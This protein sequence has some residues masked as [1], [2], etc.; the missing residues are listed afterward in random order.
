MKEELINLKSEYEQTNETNDKVVQHLTEKEQKRD[1][2]YKNDIAAK[3]E[4]ISKFETELAQLKAKLEELQKVQ[5]NEKEEVETLISEK[6][7][8]KQV[9][10]AGE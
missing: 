1:E 6:D 9:R 7:K 8:E 5:A 10:V 2:T 3:D 4:I